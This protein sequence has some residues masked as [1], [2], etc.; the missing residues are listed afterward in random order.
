MLGM[1]VIIYIY[2]PLFSPFLSSQLTSQIHTHTHT[3]IPYKTGESIVKYKKIN[4]LSASFPYLHK[5]GVLTL[6]A[7]V[8]ADGSIQYPI[9]SIKSRPTK[10]F[11]LPSQLMKSMLT[12]VI[13]AYN[14]SICL[15]Y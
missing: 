14:V 15:Y 5:N 11:Y 6:R 9:N 7:S 4:Y 3:H 2:I 8:N 12:D 13:K 1:Y 10:T